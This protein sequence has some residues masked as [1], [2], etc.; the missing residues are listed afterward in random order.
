VQLKLASESRKATFL[1]RLDTLARVERMVG[2]T[3]GFVM[4][5]ARKVADRVRGAITTWVLA[6]VKLPITLLDD[7]MGAGSWT[8]FL[9]SDGLCCARGFD[10][11][12][13]HAAA[14]S[15]W[16]GSFGWAGGLL[17]SG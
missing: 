4:D 17:Y 12:R 11:L 14:V 6:V 5:S 15:R 16:E 2:M 7:L 9:E 10:T 3:E 8:D 13:G 1:T